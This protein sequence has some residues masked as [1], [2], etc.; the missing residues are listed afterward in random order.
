MVAH[1]P[2]HGPDLQVH[3][4]HRLLTVV[5]VTGVGI[6][7][8]ETRENVQEMTAG[9]GIEAPVEIA[10]A[11]RQNVG[12]RVHHLIPV[13]EIIIV[14]RGTGAIVVVLVDAETALIVAVV[15]AGAQGD[16]E[17]DIWS[18]INP[19]SRWTITFFMLLQRII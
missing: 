18:T 12:E 14:V 7:A 15:A 3:I 2:Y 17:S 19:L 1:D 8:G 10:S 16:H 6:E 11:I 5:S 9:T 13:V 4:A